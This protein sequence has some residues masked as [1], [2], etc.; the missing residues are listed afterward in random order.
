MSLKKQVNETK[1]IAIDFVET[2]LFEQIKTQKAISSIIF[3]I[4]VLIVMLDIIPGINNWEI[5]SKYRFGP[6]SYPYLYKKVKS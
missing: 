6:N 3:F 2:Q 1:E 4:L 5:I